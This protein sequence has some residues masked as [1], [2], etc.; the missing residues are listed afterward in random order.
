MEEGA[1]RPRAPVCQH[2]ALSALVV[3]K[4]RLAAPRAAGTWPGQRLPIDTSGQG[5]VVM[6]KEEAGGSPRLGSPA[7]CWGRAPAP[8]AGWGGDRV[9]G[10]G[11]WGRLLPSRRPGGSRRRLCSRGTGAL[12]GPGSQPLG[13]PAHGGLRAPKGQAAGHRRQ[14]PLPPVPPRRPAGS[15]S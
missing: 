14:W 2:Q 15:G 7:V 3:P 8:G 10:R 1:E 5:E 6:I 4:D 13:V 9:R 12:A 11:L